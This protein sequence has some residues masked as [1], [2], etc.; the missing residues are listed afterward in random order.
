MILN[1]IKVYLTECVYHKYSVQYCLTYDS[2]LWVG[3]VSFAIYAANEKEGKKVKEPSTLFV[4]SMSHY[5]DY[6]RQRY[7]YYSGAC[8]SISFFQLESHKNSASLV[9][10]LKWPHCSNIFI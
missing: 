9:S 3:T 6:S 4:L 8:N 1:F 10:R 5:P 7:V 2:C